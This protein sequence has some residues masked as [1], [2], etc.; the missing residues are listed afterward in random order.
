MDIWDCGA[1]DWGMYIHDL[2]RFS[3]GIL[4]SAFEFKTLVDLWYR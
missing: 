3:L 2:H 1:C 4:Q